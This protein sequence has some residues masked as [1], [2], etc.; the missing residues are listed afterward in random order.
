VD[1]S[2]SRRTFVATA[3]MAATALA[4]PSIALADE[5]PKDNGTPDRAAPLQASLSAALPGGPGGRFAFFK[6]GSPGG[7]PVR[8]ELKP[9]TEDK[10]FLRAVGFK[11][12]GPVPDKVYIE[13]KLDDNGI[14]QGANDLT[15]S[16]QGTYLLQVFNYNPN[17]DA[18]MNYTLLATNIPPQGG[19]AGA[20]T[21]FTPEA[22]AFGYTAIPLVGV[23]QGTLEGG[24]GGHFRYYK[25][26]VG[27]GSTISVDMQVDPDDSAILAVAGYKLY[28]PQAGREYLQSQGNKGKTPNATGDLYVPDSGQYVLQIYNYSPNTKI[29]YSVSTRGPVNPNG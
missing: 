28:G 19:E 5:P 25:F 29:S 14:W 4:L 1:R 24:S 18:V 20:G 9:G 16:D 8:I 21:D 12:Y 7:W 2:I 22:G 6:F 23:Q 11:L 26:Q 13:G 15:S 3:A 10:N 17:A 27:A